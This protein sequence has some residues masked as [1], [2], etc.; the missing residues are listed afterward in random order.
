[1]KWA[2]DGGALHLYDLNETAGD[3]FAAEVM[4]AQSY[5]TGQGVAVLYA[6]VFEGDA[7]LA[8]LEACGF[9]L[10]A[11]ESDVHEGRVTKRLS[12]VKVCPAAS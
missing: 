11:S 12:F 5:A 10:D 7:A 8:Q 4:R 1:M 6:E 2:L 3:D 9:M